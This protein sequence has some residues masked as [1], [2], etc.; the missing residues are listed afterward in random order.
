MARFFG[1]FGSKT[2][3]VDDTSTDASSDNQAAYFLNS[4]DA[5]TLGK[6]SSKEKSKMKD[7]TPIPP[8]KSQPETPKRRS[9]DSNMDLFRKMAKDLKK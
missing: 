7:A 5:H 2:K 9:A 1:L 3:D 4:D 8:A 6:R